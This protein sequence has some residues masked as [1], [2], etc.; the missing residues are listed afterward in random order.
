MLIF[1]KFSWKTLLPTVTMLFFAG[2]AL[3]QR[4]VTGTV[5]DQET[6]ELLI[7]VTIVEK[8][9][10]GN[11]AVTD[12]EGRFSIRVG[13]NA[14]ALVVNY[15]G[16]Q[17]QEVALSSNELKIEIATNTLL[18]E[19]VVIGYG[20]VKREDAT[21]LVQA[22][23]SS[24]FNRGAIT[25]PQELLA[26]KI[27]GVAITT[28]GSPGGGSRIRIRGESSLSASNDPLIVIDGVPLASGDVSG[29][30]NPLNLI[31]PN[32]IETMTVLKDASAAAIYG[33]RASG[34][35]III[36]TKKGALGKKINI[37][38]NV[39][40]SSGETF[41]RI[42]VLSADEM[43]AAVAANYAVDHPSQALLGTA[44]T[45]WQNEIYQK[46]FGQ[47]H[48]LSI[49]GGVGMVPYRVSLGYTNKDGL[50]RTDN[51]SRYTGA[52]NLSPKF[53]AN[54]LQF[55]L[56]FKGMLSDN[57][58]ADRGAIGSALSFDPTRPVRDTSMARY[59]GY[60]TWTIANGDPNGLAP[61]NPVALL[62]LRDNNSEVQHIVTSAAMD[63]R[64]KRIP[65]LRYNINVAYDHSYGKGTLMI[66]EFAA[67]S[68]DKINGGGANNRYN[69]TRINSLL[70]TYLNYKKDFG[71][72][73]FE[74][75]GGYSWQRQWDESFSYNSN[76]SGAKARLDT[77]IDGSEIY[78]LSFF[79]R[80][81]YSFRDR[82]LLTL[83]YR[84][85]ATS[86]FAPEYRWGN[87]PGMA[88]AVKIRE[89][90]RRYFNF[91][92]ARASFGITGQQET[93]NR[94]QYQALYQQSNPNALYQLGDSLYN[95]LRANGYD[96]NSKWEENASYNFGVDFSIVRDRIGGSLDFYNKNSTDLLVF[97]AQP[98][99]SN[100]TNF[101]I[102]N[103]GTMNSRGV[104]LT[105]NLTPVA[106]RKV[107]WDVSTNLA[108]N[109][110]EITRITNRADS[111]NFVGVKT[112]G[113]SGGV[114]STIQLHTE[115]YAPS[116][117]FVY[118]QLYDGQI[119]DSDKYRYKQPN[120]V[121]TIGFT[122]NLSVGDFDFSFAGRSFLGAYIYNNVQTD[123]GYL[124]RLYH[125]TKY[126]VNVNQSAVDLNVKKQSSLTF[127]DHFVTKADFLRLDHITAGYNFQKL[128]GKS[129][130]LYGTIQN[131]LLFTQ[132]SGLDPE[133]AGG[134][135]NNT[136]PRPRTY[137]LGLSVNF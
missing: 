42:D 98:A 30:R 131:P 24:Q 117:F 57:H 2:L 52:L 6:G 100:L 5:Q 78:L 74:A 43:R 71:E 132:Y 130:R 102:D 53:L 21:G 63:Y 125:P 128:I 67:F 48:N 135:D 105:L 26:G 85:D 82:Y 36:T 22:V 31:N 17:E 79:G 121:Y 25:G 20:T 126:L 41:N 64:F 12:L 113:I 134:I 3:G 81:N 109:R 68:F 27:A 115:G 133:V 66:P 77:F 137:L 18:K 104:E 86:R 7:G 4:T 70:E 59:G 92:K 95:I 80:V 94:Y 106:T 38:Y 103:I 9:N 40:I 60:S 90:D 39:N 101:L 124:D 32:D 114:G 129:L 13:D 56:N 91:V 75:M 120:P 49:S 29:N 88:A 61:A 122:S 65:E 123:M 73:G 37:G 93:N 72:H 107:H 136:Y 19:V 84:R 116:S 14:T 54:R 34:G 83:N 58:F 76:V 111:E 1:T 50:L 97:I 119:N 55:N 11:G 35:V 8:E 15:T 23:S 69:Q 89:N 33:N 118:Q 16:Y 99:L 112:G 110:N 108:Y 62:E 46:A 10:R 44:S 96:Y 47:D 45:N 28:D 51:F 87:F 127:S